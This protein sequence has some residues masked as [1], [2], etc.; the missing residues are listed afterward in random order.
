V[1]PDGSNVYVANSGAGDEAAGTISV[2][3]AATNAV[4]AT[5][6]GVNAPFGIA[7]S[8]DGVRV[9]VT[10]EGSNNVSVIDTATEGVIPPSL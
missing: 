8:P 3:D 9:Y 1:S 5:I 4:T 6:P 7:V 2:I 10:N